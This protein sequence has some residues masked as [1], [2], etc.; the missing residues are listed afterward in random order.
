M[1]TP[2]AISLE[3]QE[4][5]CPKVL[6]ASLLKPSDRSKFLEEVAYALGYDEDEEDSAPEDYARFMG[7]KE[8]IERGEITPRV[9]AEALRYLREFA[10]DWIYEQR[11]VYNRW[12]RVFAQHGALKR[13]A[14]TRIRVQGIKREATIMVGGVRYY[15]P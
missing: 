14:P 7:A 4:V 13:Q 15:R 11:S 12:C 10:P 3:L 2:T 6:G 5:Q 9:I 8:D 1:A